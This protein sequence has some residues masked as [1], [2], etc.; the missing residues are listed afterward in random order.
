MTERGDSRG[1]SP[2]TAA[3]F[4]LPLTAFERYMLL[5]D[6]PGYPMVFAL[7]ARLSGEIDRR[8]FES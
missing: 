7:S 5:D 1:F 3:I 4:P 6:S 2:T 8:I